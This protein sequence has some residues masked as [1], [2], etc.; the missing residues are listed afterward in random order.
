MRTII[1]VLL[2]LMPLCA[3]AKGAEEMYTMWNRPDCK[4]YYIYEQKINKQR[5]GTPFAFV[6]DVT[7]ADTSLTTTYHFS[8]TEP[9]IVTLDS[10]AFIVGEHRIAYPTPTQFY[11]DKVKKGWLHR[12]ELPVLLTDL[13]SMYDSNHPLHIIAY[14]PHGE[15]NY[16]IRAA[17]WK[18]ISNRMQQI[19]DIITLNKQMVSLP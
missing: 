4:Q 18:K 17:K 3:I 14:T 19:F 16:Q 12:Y 1:I 15:L 5:G 13:E 2:G 9:K 8:I 7:Y 11:I 6:Y 10:I